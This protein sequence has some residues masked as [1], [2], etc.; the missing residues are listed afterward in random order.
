MQRFVFVL[1]FVTTVSGCI[2]TQNALPVSPSG[3]LTKYCTYKRSQLSSPCKG[4]RIYIAL[5]KLEP[6]PLYTT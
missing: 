2:A 6:I 5:H 4:I 3:I 1:G